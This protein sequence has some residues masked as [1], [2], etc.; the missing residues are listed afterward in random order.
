MRDS[1]VIPLT[2]ARARSKFIRRAGKKEVMIAA[3]GPHIPFGLHGLACPVA[4]KAAGA[5]ATAAPRV[6]THADEERSP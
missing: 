3:A 2:V 1:S 6:K 4:G 5:P